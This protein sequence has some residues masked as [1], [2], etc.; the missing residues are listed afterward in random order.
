MTR[1]LRRSVA[2]ALVVL[3]GAGLE[4]QCV[5]PPPDLV[6]WW[7]GDGHSGEIASGSAV[8]LEGTVEFAPGLVDDAFEFGGS[9]DPGAFN[10]ELPGITDQFTLDAWV[11]H[12]FASPVIQRYVTIHGN[13]TG[14]APPI[15]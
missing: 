11:R 6:R 4:A 9:E 1:M 5:S 8:F 7:P 15:S 3:S 13:D 10:G 12:V 2:V 14:S